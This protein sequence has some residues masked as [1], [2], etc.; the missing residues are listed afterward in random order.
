[1]IQGEDV[2]IGTAVA[3]MLW[4]M[5]FGSILKFKHQFF[6][7]HGS[8]PQAAQNCTPLTLSPSPKPSY[9]V[10]R[11]D[12]PCC[13]WEEQP[14]SHLLHGAAQD[15]AGVHSEEATQNSQALLVFS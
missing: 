11:H 13:Q 3:Y 10:A 8:G 1:M 6:D 15:A 9:V 4:L 14:H 12:L 7:V 2:Y 5:V